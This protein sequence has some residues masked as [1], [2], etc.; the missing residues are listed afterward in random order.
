MGRALSSEK[1]KGGGARKYGRAKKW[2]EMYRKLG[3]RRKNKIKKIRRH[4]KKFGDD[5]RAASALKRVINE[6]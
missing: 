5:K 4:I 2:C 1:G 3:M 6:I